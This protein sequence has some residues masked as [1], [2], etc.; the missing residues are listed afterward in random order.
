M[1]KRT[2]LWLIVPAVLIVLLGLIPTFWA[3]YSL[4]DSNRLSAV[5]GILVAVATLGL[6]CI[7]FYQAQLLRIQAIETQ[8]SA[9]R[10]LLAP[11]G[12]IPRNGLWEK[13]EFTLSIRNV[14][15]GVATNIRGVILPPKK[16]LKY[17]PPQFSVRIPS[18]LP[19]NQSTNAVFI[20]GGTMLAERDMISGCPVCVPQDRAPESSMPDSADLRDRC[21]ARLTLTY[22]DIF[23]IKH[24]SVF[25]ITTSGIWIGVAYLQHITKDIGDINIEKG[26]NHGRAL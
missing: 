25:D 15:A 16:D 26:R 19:I 11:E 12:D 7:T 10:P 3:W 8:Q 9:Y 4:V 6:T 17:I 22:T 23:G 21:I 13:Q 20:V 18:P 24:A 14:G 2:L 5:A 1:D